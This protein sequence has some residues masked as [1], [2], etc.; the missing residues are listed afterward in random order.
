VYRLV[1]RNQE[2]TVRP[3]PAL[4]DLYPSPLPVELHHSAWLADRVCRYL[5]RERPVDRPFFAFVGFPDP[6][7]PFTPC[8]E[9]LDLFAGQ[10]VKE[11][12]DESGQGIAD[13]PL[14]D[15]YGMDISRLSAEERR[16]II[17]YTYAMVY[18]IDLTVGRIVDALKAR[19]LW[20]DTIVVF[21]SDHGDFLGDHGRLRK[22]IV[23]ADALL[24]V[25]FVLHAPGAGLPSQVD[26]PMSNCDVMP[27]LAALTGIE[28]PDWQ[29]GRDV[30]ALLRE[31]EESHALAFCANGNPANVNYTVYD[32]DCRLTYYPYWGF[33]ELYDHRDDPGECTNL[34]ARAQPRVRALMQV[35]EQSMLR[36]HNPILGRTGAW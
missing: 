21:T 4:R 6:H 12:Y 10:Q 24:H 29:H 23:G 7:H 13:S 18:Q 26:L 20:E 19:G 8:Q 11:P 16:T 35:L 9:A 25:P 27:T 32:A 15:R 3:V 22:G 5:E 17:R 2:R 1:V 14:R 31:G 36:Y 30:T 33:C 34:A 28:P